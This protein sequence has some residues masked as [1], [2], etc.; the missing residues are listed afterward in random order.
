MIVEKTENKVDNQISYALVCI[1]NVFKNKLS[2]PIYNLNPMNWHW[3]EDCF[4]K[5]ENH[6]SVKV[7]ALFIYLFIFISP[8]F[9]QEVPQRFEVLNKRLVQ[10]HH[11]KQQIP[12]NTDKM[13]KQKVEKVKSQEL[14]FQAKVY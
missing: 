14:H 4:R 11:T 8:L 2:Q 3:T 7:K 13:L 1:K 6:N 9:Y 10:Q 12:I 5:K